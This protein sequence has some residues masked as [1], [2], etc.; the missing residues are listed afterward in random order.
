MVNFVLVE[1]FVK[2]V[3]E[4]EPDVNMVFS[5]HVVK[6]VVDKVIVNIR[7]VARDVM[8]VVGERCVN[9]ITNERTVDNVGVVHIAN[10]NFKSPNAP[11]AIE[12]VHKLFIIQNENL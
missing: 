1:I 8:I 11:Y 6:N 9:I 5:G 7:F 4:S 10:M 3:T 12:I 2:I